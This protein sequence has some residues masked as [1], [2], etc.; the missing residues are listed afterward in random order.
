VSVSVKDVEYIAGLAKLRLKEEE[1]P[2][3]TEQLNKILNYVEHLNELDTTEVEPLAHPLEMKNVFRP[4]ELKTSLSREKALA[5][6]PQRTDEYFTVPK[7][8]RR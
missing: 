7:V 3:L 1:L 6:A 2:K 4:D 8:V 5:N